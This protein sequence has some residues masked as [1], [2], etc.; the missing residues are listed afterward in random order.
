MSSHEPTQQSIDADKAVAERRKHMFTKYTCSIC[1]DTYSH[2]N[3]ARCLR[4][5]CG[6]TMSTEDV[7]DVMR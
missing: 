4:T 1:G 7:E 2:H 6:V 5:C 3:V